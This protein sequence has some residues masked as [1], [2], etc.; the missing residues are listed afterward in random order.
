MGAG[1]RLIFPRD[2]GKGGGGRTRKERRLRCNFR[3][4]PAKGAATW[5][6][7]ELCRAGHAS[8]LFPIKEGAASMIRAGMQR[9]DWEGNSQEVLVACTCRQKVE[10]HEEGI[11]RWEGMGRALSGSAT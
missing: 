2:S 7:G 4:C 8:L 5:S 6:T 1:D 9:E 11:K 3:P 10:G